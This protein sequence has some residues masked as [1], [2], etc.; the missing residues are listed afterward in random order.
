MTER[1]ARGVLLPPL[2]T[3][4]AALVTE[5]AQIS[6]GRKILLAE[7]AEFIKGKLNARETAKLNFICTHNSRRSHIAHLWAQAASYYYGGADVFCFSGGTEATAFDGRAVNAMQKAGFQIRQ[8]SQS[9]NPRYEVRF[10]DSALVVEVFSKKYDDAANPSRNF[11]AIMTCAHADK[12][13]PVVVGASKRI[14]IT[15][16]DPKDFDRTAQEETAYRDRALQI[17]REMLF[18]FSQCLG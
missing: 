10:S 3:T 13:C 11:A 7:L 15:Y 6:P 12:N 14:A 9:V 18:A 2:K 1:P 4:V 5:F 17:G 8:M 16:D